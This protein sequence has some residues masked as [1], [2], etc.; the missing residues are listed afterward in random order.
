MYGLRLDGANDGGASPLSRSIIWGSTPAR[1]VRL[2]S[3]AG[4]GNM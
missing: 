1:H 4:S 2:S 3:S